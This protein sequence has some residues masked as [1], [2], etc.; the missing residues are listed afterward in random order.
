LHLLGQAIRIPFV[1]LGPLATPGSRGVHRLGAAPLM[2]EEDDDA[3][4][5]DDVLC[6]VLMVT[7]AWYIAHVLWTRARRAAERAGAAVARGVFESGVREPQ[8]TEQAASAG[9]RRCGG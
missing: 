1:A 3:L 9:E 6:L 7:Y 4:R 2:E 8:I 5:L